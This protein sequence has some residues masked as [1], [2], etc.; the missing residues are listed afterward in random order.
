[1]N[2]QQLILTLVAFLL[3]VIVLPSLRTWLKSRAQNEQKSLLYGFIEEL[4]KAAEQMFDPESASS[5][6]MFNALKKAYVV[7]RAT[8]FV[9]QH[10]I[11]VTEEQIE[12][13]IEAAVYAMKLWQ[14]KLA[15]YAPADLPEKKQELFTQGE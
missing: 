1:M 7:K 13:L 12:A 3:A 14:P 8:E 10:G 11:G 4:V 9:R 5:P 2:L 6:E 15:H